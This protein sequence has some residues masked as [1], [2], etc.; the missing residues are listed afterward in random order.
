[1]EGTEV[2]VIGPDDPRVSLRNQQGLFATRTWA[3]R[4]TISPYAA[5]VVTAGEFD[6]AMSR[7]TLRCRW[8][9]QRYAITTA[10]K[11]YVPAAEPTACQPSLSVEEEEEEEPL[12]FCALDERWSNPTKFINDPTV[13]TV[14]PASDVDPAGSSADTQSTR[15]GTRRTQAQ[16]TAPNCQIVETA[17]PR[18]GWPRLHVVTTRR[19]APG[20][21]FC[22]A[23]GAEYWEHETC[24]RRAVEDVRAAL[25]SAAAA[26]AGDV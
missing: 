7:G 4:E 2:R 16:L 6:T 15:A 5:V 24:L 20:E 13:T 9:H 10:G 22:A 14:G 1:M 25:S 26:A 18:T 12:V 19:V 11:V 17:D 8:R 21:E 3:P 23:Y